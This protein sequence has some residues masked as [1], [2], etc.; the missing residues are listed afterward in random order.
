MESTVN[1][2]KHQIMSSIENEN[3]LEELETA[4]NEAEA[5]DTVLEDRRKSRIRH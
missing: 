3:M 2:F 5:L 1:M 4:V